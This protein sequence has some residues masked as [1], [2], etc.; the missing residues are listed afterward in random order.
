MYQLG[1]G[2]CGYSHSIML[3]VEHRQHFN[4]ALFDHI[5][6]NV[7]IEQIFQH[8]KKTTLTGC[9]AR[10]AAGWLARSLMK[11]SL[12][13]VSFKKKLFQVDSAGAMTRSTP[14]TRTLTFFT[15]SGKRISAGKR[16]A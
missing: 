6:D 8:L 10:F 13:E 3:F 15:E 9:R 4:W 2:D 1:E 5:N 11:S 16:T 7:G 12:T 14:T